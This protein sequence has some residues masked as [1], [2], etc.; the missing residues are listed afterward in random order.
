MVK[1][2][3]LSFIIDKNKLDEINEINN[4]FNQF[5][6]NV[7]TPSWIHMT[8]VFMG[9]ALRGKT[10]GELKG[11]NYIIESAVEKLS[12]LGNLKLEFDRYDYLPFNSNKKKLIL[13][14]Y[15][16]NKKLDEWVVDL[17]NTLTQMGVCPSENSFMP[18]IT[19]GRVK[20]A[21]LPDKDYLKT[22]EVFPDLTVRGLY[23]CGDQ[24][25]YIT[26]SFNLS[27]GDSFS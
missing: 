20:G 3:W 25:K 27:T 19:I 16:K 8:V 1:N 9:K 24:N 2:T 12:E 21:Y 13:A 10:V 17:K 6:I 15:K 4:E 18:H 22:V 11:I 23:V 7:M 14:I 26:N 5:D